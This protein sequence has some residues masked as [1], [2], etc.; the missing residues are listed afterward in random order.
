MPNMAELKRRADIRDVWAAL[1]G[2]KLRRLRGQAFWR[3]GDGYNV[4]LNTRRGTWH[5]FVT[6]D[7]GDVIELVRAVH[8]CGFMD[9][10][11]WLAHHTGVLVSSWTREERTIDA[12]WPT[13]L[14][15]AIWW[16]LSAEA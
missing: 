7:G 12:D 4:L 14:K 11:E 1:G 3:N 13:D 16:S 2:G 6:G 15:W 9:A 10:A 8:Q 5:D